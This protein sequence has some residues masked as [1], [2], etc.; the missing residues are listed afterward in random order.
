MIT[1]AAFVP[2]P[3]LLVPALGP[4]ADE[5]L[6]GMRS[7]VPLAIA[8]ILDTE[9][10][11]LVLIGAAPEN[12]RYPAD[13]TGTLLPYG[14]DVH[15][16]LGRGGAV[17]LP[18][19]LTIGAYVLRD[20]PVPTAAFGVANAFA[21][22]LALGE[23][24]ELVNNDRVAL[25]VLGDG[26]ARRSTAAPGYL[27]ERAEAFDATVA[28]A[29]SSADAASLAGLDL[30]LGGTLLAAGAPTWQLAGTLLGGR[31]RATSYYA[32]APFGV[33]YFVASWLGTG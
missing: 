18:L 33:G 13:V 17:E 3:P 21:D 8:D 14:L 31:F 32:G 1:A 15:Y 6:A 25:L 11:R 16:D 20:S 12:T 5:E 7:A 30:T 23:L 27:D 26:S 9:P 22:S 29:L 19:S 28:D 10:E 24:T 2:H 4:G